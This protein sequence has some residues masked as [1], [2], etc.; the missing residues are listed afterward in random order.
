V[1]IISPF[2][3]FSAGPLPITDEGVVLD[4]SLYRVTDVLFGGR[5]YRTIY[6]WMF[7]LVSRR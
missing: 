5:A 7:R 1:A 3:C 4:Y 6:G 2:F